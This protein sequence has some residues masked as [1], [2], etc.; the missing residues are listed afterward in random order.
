MNGYVYHI[1]DP[2]NPNLEHGYIGV[3]KESKGIDK[4]FRE[5][6]LAKNRMSSHIREN[7]ISLN[8]VDI[9][10]FGDIIECY[11]KEKALRPNQNMGWNLAKGGGG[12]Y[13]SEIE[14]LSKHR[15]EIQSQ[16]MKDENLKKQQSKSFKRNYYS[17]AESQKLRSLRAKESM[18][19]QD[20][21]EKALKGLHSKHKCPYCDLET[22]KGNLTR[23]IK[24]K[25]ND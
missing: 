2:N 12:P 13:Y 20:T 16:R 1:K 14:D 15:S 10:F 7:S 6:S 23:H 19:N 4:R 5:H 21:K 11:E 8:D 24:A 3:V 25:H 22:N 18:S 9:L 17:N